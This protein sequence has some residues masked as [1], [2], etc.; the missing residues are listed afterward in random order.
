MWCLYDA[1]PPLIIFIWWGSYWLYWG[2]SWLS[3]RRCALA[4]KCWQNSTGTKKHLKRAWCTKWPVTR[5]LKSTL[6]FP[7]KQAD[8]SLWSSKPVNRV[9]LWYV[10]SLISANQQ[11]QRSNNLAIF[12]QIGSKLQLQAQGHQFVTCRQ[13][14]YHHRQLS[15]NRLHNF[16]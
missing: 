1:T 9:T 7:N 12:E 8:Q 6:H 4:R 5:T 13:F 3:G 15:S 16:R 14:P 10:L 11:H 2:S